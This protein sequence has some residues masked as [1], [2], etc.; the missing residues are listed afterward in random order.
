M[1]AVLLAAGCKSQPK[2]YKPEPQPV[3][4]NKTVSAFQ[5]EKYV[6]EDWQYGTN[7]VKSVQK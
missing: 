3:Q 7:R 2:W 4:T 5:D 6:W 1:I